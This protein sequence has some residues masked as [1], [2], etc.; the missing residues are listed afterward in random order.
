MNKTII[1]GKSSI[2]IDKYIK[3]NIL[4]NISQSL[5]EKYLRKGLITL[6]DQKVSSNTRVKEGQNLL[7]NTII[8]FEPQKKQNIHK[9]TKDISLRDEI[10]YQDN[11]IIALNKSSGIAVQGGHKVAFSINDLLATQFNRIN[12]EIP[13]IVH[14]LDKDTSGVLLLARTLESAQFLAQSF[15]NRTIKKIYRALVIGTL[16]K[17]QGKIDIPLT[18]RY[19]GNQEIICTDESQGKQAITYFRTLKIIPEQN[20]SYIEIEPITGRKHQIRA[21]MKHIGYPIYGDKKYGAQK[22]ARLS[23]HAYSINLT[24]PDKKNITITAPIPQ[25]IHTML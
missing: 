18:Q 7:I 11:Y 12:N 16:D 20:I 6:D 22:R 4:H 19:V 25:H 2:R 17:Q 15:S 13:R 5:I 10:L 24:L 14:R 8:N 21:H 23:L 3:R 1:I 9:K